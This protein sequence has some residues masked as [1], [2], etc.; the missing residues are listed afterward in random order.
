MQKGF[1]PI[2]ILV[3]VLAVVG[4]VGGVYYVYYSG[5]LPIKLPFSQSP[6]PTAQ[7]TKSDETANWKTF[8][9][10]VDNNGTIHYISLKYPPTWFL[11]RNGNSA[12]LYPLG[13]NR[14]PTPQIILSLQGTGEFAGLPYLETKKYPVGNVRIS[15]GDTGNP[16]LDFGLYDIEAGPTIAVMDIPKKDSKA[17]QETMDQILSTFKF[18]P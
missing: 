5:K 17:Y 8:T 10:S 7:P 11:D 1:V 6:F 9:G 12:S 3:G 16:D 14:P 18:T 2:L 13:K 15:W 4:L